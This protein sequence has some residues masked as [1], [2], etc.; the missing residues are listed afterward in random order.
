MRVVCVCM[1]AR[2][3]VCVYRYSNNNININY[4]MHNALINYR[5]KRITRENKMFYLQNNYLIFLF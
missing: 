5:S 3:R 1:C 2:V 4:L